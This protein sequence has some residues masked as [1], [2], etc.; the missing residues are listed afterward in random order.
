MPTSSG[1]PHRG[2]A[3]GRAGGLEHPGAAGQEDAPRHQGRA[4]SPEGGPGRGAVGIGHLDRPLEVACDGARR[5]HAAVVDPGRQRPPAGAEGERG[6]LRAGGREARPADGPLAPGR[7][8][9]GQADLEPLAE[10]LD[11]RGRG[12][13]PAV[14]RD[15]EI[16]HRRHRLG[17]AA[18]P[19]GPRRPVPDGRHDQAP[20]APDGGG[21]ATRVQRHARERGAR[22][23]HR[24]RARPSRG[25]RVAPRSAP[26]PP[27]RSARR[28]ADPGGQRRAAR[29]RRDRRGPVGG[30]VGRRHAHGGAP[31]GRPRG[32]GQRQGRRAEEAGEGEG[33]PAHRDRRYQP[34]RRIPRAPGAA[35][36]PSVDVLHRRPHRDPA[37][38]PEDVGVVVAGAAVRVV[39]PRV[40]RAGTPG[41]SRGSRSRGG[42]RAPAGRR[43]R[44]GRRSWSRPGSEP[45]GVGVDGL[46][47][48]TGKSRTSFPCW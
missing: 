18:G 15:G 47:N 45:I 16:L 3:A 21:V 28:G 48:T 10:P 41:W 6:R 23:G 17:D 8:G 1:A 43:R 37:P 38:Q 34:G 19:P 13:S 2:A 29:P 12:P 35:A 27:P 32:R 20:V 30:P 39:P 26:A 44:S 31:R 40:R 36:R 5:Q 33:H 46:P 4:R 22:P 25:R 11:P 42:T 7:V 9:G 24:P 14:E